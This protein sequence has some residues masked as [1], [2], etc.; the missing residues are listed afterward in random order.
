MLVELIS[1][2]TGGPVVIDARQITTVTEMELGC[3]VNIGPFYSI[4]VK[5]QPEYIRRLW[6]AALLRERAA[7]FALAIVSSNWAER[8]PNC[9]VWQ[10]AQSLA[11]AEPS[12]NP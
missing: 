4:D 3:R 6:Q 12:S 7:Q 10:E 11:D 8:L 2:T 9:R 1:Q 5:E